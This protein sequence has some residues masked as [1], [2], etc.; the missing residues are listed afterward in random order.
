MW[1]CD[2]LQKALQEKF[3]T[4]GRSIF[5]SCRMMDGLVDTSVCTP[6]HS[7]SLM[8]SIGL[9]LYLLLAPFPAKIATLI[10]KLATLFTGKCCL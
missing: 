10:E 5:R 1:C 7:S 9:T 8:I 3:D 6:S 2:R 4:C